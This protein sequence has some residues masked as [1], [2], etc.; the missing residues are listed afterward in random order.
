[1]FI[2]GTTCLHILLA[3]SC[4]YYYLLS[5][6]YTVLHIILLHILFSILL[7]SIFDYSFFS[8]LYLCLLSCVCISYNCTVHGADLTYIS[9]LIIFCIIV[10]VTNKYLEV[11]ENCQAKPIQTLGRASQGVNWSWSQCIKSHH[12][13][14]SSGKETET[15]SEASY[16]G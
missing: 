12:A 16:L 14:T 5:L 8:Y 13:Q 9:L 4:L 2:P 3:H 15:L 1:M 10:Y 11:W 6:Q 7:F